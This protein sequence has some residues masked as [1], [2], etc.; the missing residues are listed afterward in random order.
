MT[1]VLHGLDVVVCRPALQSGPL[2]D[3][4]AELGGVP[5]ALPLLE[6]AAPADGG[7]ALEAA[8]GRIDTFDWL[9]VTST[10]AVAAVAAKR[11]T[12]PP[13]LRIAAVGPAT[14]DAARAQGWSVAFEPSAATAEVLGVE[15][16]L[17]SG[18]EAVLAPLAELAAETLERTL[19]ERGAAFERVDA[20]RMAMPTHSAERVEQALHADVV[21]LS[22]PSTAQRLA[23]LA[24]RHTAERGRPAKLPRAVVI[25]PSTEQAALAAGFDVIAIA[26][27]HTE[28]GLVD[29]LVRSIG[30]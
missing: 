24:E 4:I 5:I 17:E 22:S 20:Y 15:I 12:L 23:E 9:I 28:A 16:P 2:L 27:P 10:N 13:S 11:S 30:S 1:G 29:A 26:D 19:T 6:F 14:A 7:A 18:A 21:L 8:L 3:T 25:G